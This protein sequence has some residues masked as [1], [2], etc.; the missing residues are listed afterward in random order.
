MP[1][2][3]RLGGSA[4]LLCLLL[5]IVHTWP[6]AADPGTHSRNDNGDTQLN[7]WILAW[8]AHQLPRAPARVFDANIF[9]P[10]RDTLAYSEP[11]LVQGL[12]SAP[13]RWMG[14]SPVLAFNVVLLLGFALTAWAGYRLI[15]EW[16]R[17]RAAGLLAGSHV[18]VQHAHAH[19]AGAHPGDSR[20]GP[21]ARAPVHR[22]ADRARPH[23]RRT[24]AGVLDAVPGRDI[25]LS[26]GFRGGARRCRGD[27]TVAV[28]VA[29][30]P[31]CGPPRRTRRRADRSRRGANR[32]PLSAGRDRARNGPFDR[33]RGGLLRAVE[34]LHHVGG[35]TT[36]LAVEQRV[37]QRPDRPVLPG[38]NRSGTSRRWRSSGP[39][40][41]PTTEQSRIPCCNSGW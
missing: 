22:S 16:T 3:R 38:R 25:R 24:V 27:C 31:R 28:V 19:A 18:R 2:L 8:V 13:L 30:C 35:A 29:S 26:R 5:A 37:L 6:L 21:A 1:F 12:M 20:V 9:Y 11:L 34:V 7:E 39:P 17:S 23:A 36:L 41:A 33:E 4:A 10:E 40:R 15:H 32:D 14:A